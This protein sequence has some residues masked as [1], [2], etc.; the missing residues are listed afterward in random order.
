MM[1][2]LYKAYKEKHKLSLVEMSR[3]TGVHYKSMW[4]FEQ[5]LPLNEE[6]WKRLTRWM[7]A[8]GP[9]VPDSRTGK[10]QLWRKD[11]NVP[12]GTISEP[13]VTNEQDKARTRVSPLYTT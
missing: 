13:N 12:R 9:P 7:L 8:D 6:H 4:R 11:R 2:E 3:L 5:G 1:L 10:A